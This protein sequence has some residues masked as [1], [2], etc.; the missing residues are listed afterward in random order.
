MCKVCHQEWSAE[1]IYDDG[2]CHY[3]WDAHGADWV[4]VKQ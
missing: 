3:C 1:E 4:G 2:V